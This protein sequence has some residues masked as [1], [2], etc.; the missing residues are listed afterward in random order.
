MTIDR[1]PNCNAP[2]HATEGDDLGRCATCRKLEAAWLVVT[3]HAD[4]TDEQI[5]NAHDLVRHGSGG[6]CDFTLDRCYAETD[7]EALRMLDLAR[8]VRDDGSDEKE[9]RR[10]WYA[11]RPS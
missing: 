2:T 8:E 7:R 5:V 4:G 6:T 11:G 1:C 10:R 3:T 9:F